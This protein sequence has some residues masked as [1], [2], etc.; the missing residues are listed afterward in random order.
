MSVVKVVKDFANS[1]PMAPPAPR[2]V[3]IFIEFYF[4]TKIDTCIFAGK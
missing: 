4:V 2:I 1:T 3:C